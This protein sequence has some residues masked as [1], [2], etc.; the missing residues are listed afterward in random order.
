MKSG[1]VTP[2]LLR[3]YQL[4]LQKGKEMRILK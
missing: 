2:E 1:S 4:L 3:E